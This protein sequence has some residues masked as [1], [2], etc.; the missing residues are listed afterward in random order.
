MGT[1]PVRF[2]IPAAQTAPLLALSEALPDHC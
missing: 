2:R 1:P